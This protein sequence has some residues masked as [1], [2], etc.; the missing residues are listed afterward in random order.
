LPE[1]DFDNYVDPDFMEDYTE[2]MQD[3]FQLVYPSIDEETAAGLA[4]AV[5]AFET[6]IARTA[7]PFAEAAMN[8]GAYVSVTRGPREKNGGLAFQI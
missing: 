5:S 3:I 2:T 7:I 4:E 1:P 6:D 8:L